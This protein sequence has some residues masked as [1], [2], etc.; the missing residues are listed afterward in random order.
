MCAASNVVGA[1][2][3]SRLRENFVRRRPYMGTAAVLAITEVEAL[4]APHIAAR[5][6]KLS[7]A[8]GRRT[9]ADLCWFDLRQRIPD[10]LLVRTDRATMG[11][12]IE[13]RVPFLD[14]DLIELVLA[15]PPSARAK[16]GM[17]KVVPRLL[18]HRWGVPTRTL[19]HRKIGFQLP[20]GPWFR[21]PLRP[22]W[23]VVLGER[24]VPG[25]Q[26]EEVARMYRIHQSG[27]GNFE[28]MLWRVAA[29]G[30]LSIGA[31]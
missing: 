20:L 8:G 5:M 21:G 28:E 25:I 30:A 7:H 22:F 26:Y 29:L 6:G 18:A 14:P 19:T 4:L 23:R 16:V 12:S 24:A 11:A 10:D 1:Q 3:V 2:D 13:A 17:S 9:L 15:L 31:G 27:R